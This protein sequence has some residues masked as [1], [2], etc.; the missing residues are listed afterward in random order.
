MKPAV[1][2][3]FP[4]CTD[5][6]DMEAS[7]YRSRTQGGVGTVS[8]GQKVSPPMSRRSVWIQREVSLGGSCPVKLDYSASDCSRPSHKTQL[9][10]PLPEC[11]WTGW[12]VSVQVTEKAKCIPR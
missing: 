2:A 11:L 12:Y 4:S 1:D 9:L 5:E 6:S 3:W 10:Q 8:P 7:N